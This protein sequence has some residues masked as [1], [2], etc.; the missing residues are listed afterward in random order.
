M[1][2]I[3]PSTIF[4]SKRRLSLSVLKCK[5]RLSVQVRRSNALGVI[6]R[7]MIQLYRHGD[8]VHFS[9]HTDSQKNKPFERRKVQCHQPLSAGV[10][11]PSIHIL[12]ASDSLV[13]LEV[14]GAAAGR[15][16][17]KSR[18]APPLTNSLS[19]AHTP[20]I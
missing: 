11:G 14:V 8:R 6:D 10:R 7:K 18:S 1:Y 20:I 17:N 4:K 3:K 19:A 12:G 5:R 15:R 2:R 13:R 9:R 16:K